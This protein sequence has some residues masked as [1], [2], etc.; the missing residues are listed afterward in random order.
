MLL[1]V[2]DV[3][4]ETEELHGLKTTAVHLLGD[5]QHGAGAHAQRPQTQGAIA[6]RR[7]DKTNFLHRALRFPYLE[8]PSCKCVAD[9][10][11]TGMNVPGACPIHCIIAATRPT[12]AASVFRS[13]KK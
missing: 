4:G 12:V 11:E 5:R 9:Q 6:D 10:F 2:L 8:N 1:D 7:I 13:N 3:A